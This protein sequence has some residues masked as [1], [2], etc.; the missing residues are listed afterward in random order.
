[1]QKLITV[2]VFLITM[3]FFGQEKFSEHEFSLNG[4]RNPSIGAEYRYKH[5]S[6]HAGYYP[7]NFESGVTTEF[8]R[9]GL[10]YWF[11]P[12][13]QKENPSSFY[14]SVSY[15]RGMSRDYK[16]ENAVMTEAGFR[17]M[18]YKGLNLRLGITA[19][20]ANDKS[21]KI[22]PTPGISYSFFF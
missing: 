11:L 16:D 19:L 15:A 4:F 10:T 5:V 14:A 7:T 3:P 13:G 20:A 2:A 12:V 6:V 9:T 8:I 17:W 21:L 18:V 22:N 1:M